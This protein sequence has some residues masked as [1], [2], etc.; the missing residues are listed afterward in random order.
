ME[1]DTPVSTYEVRCVTLD[2]FLHGRPVQ[3]IHADVE[4]SEEIVLRGARK[5]IAKHRPILYLEN[6][7]EPQAPGLVAE[8]RRQGYRAFWHTVPLFNPENFNRCAKNVFEARGAAGE[9]ITLTSINILCFHESDTRFDV[10]KLLECTPEQPTFPRQPTLATI[11]LPG[12]LDAPPL[13]APR[14]FLEGAMP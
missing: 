5:T 2:E 11:S 3:F 6:D 4:G 8:L 7:R 13:E 1:V 12:I 10:S 14:S 9:V